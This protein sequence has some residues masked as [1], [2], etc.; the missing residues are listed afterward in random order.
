VKNQQTQKNPYLPASITS[1]K[2]IMSD[3]K[4]K[5]STPRSSN[6][7]QSS[8]SN[9]KPT[10]PL[11]LIKSF[12]GFD[13]KSPTVSL[14]E[15]KSHTIIM[16]NAPSAVSTCSRT[17]FTSSQSKNFHDGFHLRA[18]FPCFDIVQDVV[19]SDM[20]VNAFSAVCSTD[21]KTYTDQT[22]GTAMLSPG[23]MQ[24]LTSFTEGTSWTAYATVPRFPGVVNI[25]NM[26]S[27]YRVNGV[28][29]EYEPSSPTTL[30]E[31]YR[32]SFV[33][34]PCHP[35]LGRGAYADGLGPIFA[36]AATATESVQFAP[37]ARWK[38]IPNT[39]PKWLY[40]Y[41]NVGNYI[42]GGESPDLHADLELRSSY[43]G[44]ITCVCDTVKTGLYA[45]RGRLMMELDIEFKDFSPLNV[46]F[47]NPLFMRSKRSNL[48]RNAMISYL[49]VEEKSDDSK[50]PLLPQDTLEP[51]VVVHRTAVTGSP[52]FL[53]ET[54]SGKKPAAQHQSSSSSSTSSRQST[55]RGKPLF[56]G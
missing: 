27:Q 10:P 52:V 23:L 25:A 43:F 26:F 42:G 48:V 3:K 39:Q 29:F 5:I 45:G 32:F 56:E 20:Q 38:M 11:P 7:S 9:P 37:W 22:F 24:G 14:K 46:A 41:G 1:T 49:T 34:D 31:M 13:L 47:T 15:N 12:H 35:M 17:Y 51:A 19:Q 2:L 55:S 30:T 33:E 4:S 21:G 40:T 6:R 28:S 54:D 44:C 36:T 50:E 8:S 18:R 16:D 53:M